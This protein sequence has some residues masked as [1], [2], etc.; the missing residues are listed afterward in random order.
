MTTT[1]NHVRHLNINDIPMLDPIDV[2]LEDLGPG[3]GRI[4]MQCY[5]DAW[6]A[7]FGAMGNS[8]IHVFIALAS[9]DYLSSK[10]LGGNHK[11]TKAHETYLMKIIDTVKTVLV[12][13]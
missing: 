8:T 4:T 10:F 5:G 3:R 9:T 1:E 11:R 6:T 13:S 7:Y 12:A 2:F